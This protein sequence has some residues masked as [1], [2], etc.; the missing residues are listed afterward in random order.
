MHFVQ[1]ERRK[2]SIGH[3]PD[4]L[5]GPCIAGT[6][7]R[8][9]G[10]SSQRMARCALP[11]HLFSTLYF[12]TSLTIWYHQ[13][14]AYLEPDLSQH[15][16]KNQTLTVAQILSLLQF[17]SSLH[18]ILNRCSSYHAKHFLPFGRKAMEENNRPKRSKYFAFVFE[19]G[20][21]GGPWARTH[22]TICLSFARAT[23]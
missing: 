19:R 1:G 21:K 6:K 13:C 14:F 4:R 3:W 17:H 2:V 12:L 10:T 9:S 5:I 20:K 23:A 7:C 8:C 15:I 22:Q 11:L 16:V 18:F